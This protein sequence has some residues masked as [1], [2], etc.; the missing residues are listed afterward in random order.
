MD[1]KIAVLK[2]TWLYFISLEA[3]EPLDKFQVSKWNIWTLRKIT[4]YTLPNITFP[5]H[6]FRQRNGVG[7]KAVFFIFNTRWHCSVFFNWLEIFF[8]FLIFFLTWEAA[9]AAVLNEAVV[10][11]QLHIHM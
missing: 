4:V 11:H 7:G 9:W 8:F 6:S 10:T 1:L 2:L 3:Q 5:T